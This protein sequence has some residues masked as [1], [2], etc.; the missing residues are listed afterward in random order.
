MLSSCCLGDATI[1][2]FIAKLILGFFLN[3]VTHLWVAS[4]KGDKHNPYFVFQLYYFLDPVQSHKVAATAAAT[5]NNEH[6]SIYALPEL[7]IAV[8]VGGIDVDERPELVSFRDT[9]YREQ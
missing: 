3:R 4:R 6:A 7:C 8:K 1:P 9:G 2:S 5:N